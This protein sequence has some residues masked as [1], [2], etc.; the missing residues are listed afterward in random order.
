MHFEY[1]WERILTQNWD[2]EKTFSPKHH[3]LINI[4]AF[5]YRIE[6]EACQ[7]WPTYAS[8]KEDLAMRKPKW[9]EKYGRG[10]RIVLWDMTNIESFGFSDADSQQLTYSKYYNQNCFKVGCLSSCLDG[11]ALVSCGLGK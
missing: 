6:M 5:K 1:K 3:V 11:L 2:A 10:K 9:N 7:M 4:V 8:H